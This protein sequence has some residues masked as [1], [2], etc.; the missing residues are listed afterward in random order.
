M[1]ILGIIAV[2]AILVATAVPIVTL[3][4]GVRGHV[5]YSTNGAYS[6]DRMS[7]YYVRYTKELNGSTTISG[8]VSHT[9]T[10]RG[11]EALMYVHQAGILYAATNP[12]MVYGYSAANYS[13]VGTYRTGEFPAALCYVSGNLFLLPGQNNLTS[14][15]LSDFANSSTEV[16]NY[17]QKMFYDPALQAMLVTVQNPDELVAVNVTSGTVMYRI[18]LNSGP[19]GIIYDNYDGFIYYTLPSSGLI[20][21]FNPLTRAFIKNITVTGSPY[22]FSIS[23]HNNTL[24][25]SNQGTSDINVINGNTNTVVSNISAGLSPSGL[26]FDPQSYYVFVC[27]TASGNVTVIDPASHRTVQNITVGNEPYSI[28]YDGATGAV[29]VGNMGSGSLSLLYPV[30][31]NLVVFKETGL[32]KGA[33]WNVNVGGNTRYSDSNYLPFD[34]P[35][36][37]HSYSL[38][39]VQGY[40]GPSSGKIE[41]SG[42]MVVA[43]HYSYAARINTEITAIAIVVGIEA[44]AAYVFLGRSM[45][46]WLRNHLRERKK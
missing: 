40:Y 1:K 32:A 4:S 45:R 19:F 10:Q 36:G 25:V 8:I 18:H 41:V 37:R 11:P 9:A 5:F 24:F 21:V 35:S 30:L 14:I 44:V 23:T 27:N 43:L 33:E 16:G 29:V 22:E 15:N 28:T 6:P 39:V 3:D 7:K 31:H 20:S 46:K 2:A 42:H 17:P 38:S 13:T 26:A 12:D 34:L